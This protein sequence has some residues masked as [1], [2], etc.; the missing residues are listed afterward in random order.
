MTNLGIGAEVLIILCLVLVNGVFAMSEIAVISARR[1]RLRMRAEKGDT[2]ARRALDLAENPNR[3]LS[4]AQIGITLV[5]I[6]AGAYGGATVAGELNARFATVAWLA[7]YS[8]KLAL[9]TVVLAITSLSLVIGELVPKRIA[10]L[11]SERIAARIAEPMHLLSLI[12]APAVRLLGLAT[13]VVL[14]LLRIRA[15]EEPPVTEEE[16]TAMIL[17]GTQTGVFEEAERD[18]VERVFRLG[19]HTVASLMTPRESVVWLDLDDPDEVNRRKM[20]RRRVQRFPVCD[21]GIDNLLGMVAVTDLWART[22]DGLPLDLRAALEQPLA[23]PETMRALRLLDL[24]RE[25]GVH[26]ALVVDAAGRFTGLVTLTDILNEIS[27]DLLRHAEPRIIQ[28]DDGS[29]LM[30]GALSMND[31]RAVIEPDA[32]RIGG[33]TVEQTLG[34]FVAT[35]LGH[36]PISGEHFDDGGFR[37]EVMDM[38]GRHVDKVLVAALAPTGPAE[39]VEIQPTSMPEEPR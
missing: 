4:T 25:T 33:A 8:E 34:G 11:H 26:L 38:D 15:H 14:A 18:L 31:V 2:G 37:F 27:G 30:D 39:R 9:A 20:L 7:P 28:R 6:L 5:G 21:G 23:V 22:L 17:L 16:I 1:S 19:D 3:F 36:V 13:D 32:D 12:A 29:W 10:L 35:R 24:F